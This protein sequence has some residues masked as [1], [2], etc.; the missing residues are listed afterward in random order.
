[1]WKLG[2]GWDLRDEKCKYRTTD[3]MSLRRL[4]SFLESNKTSTSIKMHDFN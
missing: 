3:F 2:R 1:M 4:S